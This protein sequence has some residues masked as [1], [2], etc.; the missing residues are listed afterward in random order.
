MAKHTFVIESH[1]TGDD[2]KTVEILSRSDVATIAAR[3][4]EEAASGFARKLSAQERKLTKVAEHATAAAKDAS[5][6]REMVEKLVETAREAFR[7]VIEEMLA[8]HYRLLAQHLGIEVAEKKPKVM[9]KLE[10][11]SSSSLPQKNATPS[12]KVTP[13]KKKAVALKKTTASRSVRKGGKPC[14]KK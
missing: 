11:D 5:A 12:K 10:E 6:A 13:S 2:K 3:A 14:P 8:P 9:I 4:A 1:L 7:D